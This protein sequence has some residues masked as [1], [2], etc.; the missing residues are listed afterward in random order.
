[1]T[2][3]YHV[4]QFIIVL[5]VVGFVALIPAASQARDVNGC[6]VKGPGDCIPIHTVPDDYAPGSFG[7]MVCGSGYYFN[8]Y[9]TCTSISQCQLERTTQVR[10]CVCPPTTGADLGFCLAPVEGMTPCALT[11]QSNEKYC[12]EVEEC[13]RWDQGREEVD[14][15]A[16]GDP[17]I[18]LFT[19]NITIPGSKYFNR[20]EPIVVTGKTFGEYIAAFYFYFVSIAGILATVMMM[21]GGVLYVISTGN[22]QKLSEAKDVITSSIMGLLIA[23]C[24]YAILLLINPNLV[25]F[26]GISVYKA[27]SLPRYER[28][29]EA[30]GKSTYSG[31]QNVSTFDKC[32]TAEAKTNTIDRNWLKAM[33][34]VESAG[35]PSVVSSAKACGLIQ[36]LPSTA[37]IYEPNTSCE[38]LKD[39]WVNIRIAAR[40]YKA[41]LINPCPKSAQ[42]KSGRTATCYPKLTKCKP[43][44]H[45]WA[46]AAYNGGE[47]ANCNSIEPQCPKQTWW[48]CTKNKG[49]EETR[50]HVKKV[51]AAHDKIVASEE[52]PAANP[53]FVW[54]DNDPSI[55]TCQQ[56]SQGI[57]P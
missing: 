17:R 9:Q 13:I 38:D 57:V 51:T 19:P 49:F 21:Y 11:C 23:L 28:E 20:G 10:C 5:V 12:S 35:N 30:Q 7:T 39:P 4:V 33:M 31:R 25:K 42:Y 34:L 56:L 15:D 36:L 27:I 43:G 14:E 55:P 2:N 22:Q 29:V 41:L 50:N 45:Q 24:S 44:V 8:E 53:K 3:R 54:K 40:H 26:N 16:L 47:K 52:N 1:M 6:C 46:V 18:I 48:E 37:S 32:L